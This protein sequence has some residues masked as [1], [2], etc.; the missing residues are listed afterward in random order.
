MKIT[1]CPDEF[2]DFLKDCGVIELIALIRDLKKYP[3]D[4]DYLKA[5][6]DEVKRRSEAIADKNESEQKQTSTVPEDYMTDGPWRV[7]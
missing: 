2:K 7:C 1:P 5:A 3:E 4:V 6:N